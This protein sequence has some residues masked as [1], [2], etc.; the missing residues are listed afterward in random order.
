MIAGAQKS[1]TTALDHYLRGHDRI[2]LASKKEL[3]FFDVDR[4]FRRGGDYLWY[5]SFFDWQDRSKVFGEATPSYLFSE[6]AIVRM[7][8]YNPNLKVIVVLRNPAHRAFS[9]WNMERDRGEEP[10]DFLD[11]VAEEL[12]LIKN[13]E[14]PLPSRSSYLKRGLYAQQLSRLWMLFPRDQTLVLRYEALRQ[15]PDT[16]LL[17]VCSFLEVPPLTQVAP[18]TVHARQYERPLFEEEQAILDEV[19]R[20]DIG[21]LENLLGW[22]CSSWRYSS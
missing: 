10:L 17:E 21:A 15:T 8:A 4:H 22:D 13:N 12:A 20:D 19:F 16:C 3:H 18:A 9:H 2:S 5:H 6:K 11:A 14:S 7:R 1:G